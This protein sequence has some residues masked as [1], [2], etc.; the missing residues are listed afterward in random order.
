MSPPAPRVEQ[1]A[2]TPEDEFF[3]EWGL[4][5]YKRNLT[6]ANDILQRLVTLNGVLLGGS[7]AFYDEHIVPPTLKPVVLF[8]FFVS[9]VL[10]FFGMMPYEQ[11]IDIRI[12]AL[13]KEFKMRALRSKRRCLWCA[14]GFLTTG[15]GICFVAILHRVLY[16]AMR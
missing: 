10:S 12:P 6:L 11:K 15:F 14:G 4:E 7:I 13:V 1:V 5:T 9:L 2:P 3:V 16:G 8:C